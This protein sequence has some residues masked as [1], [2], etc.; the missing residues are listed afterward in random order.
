MWLL[1]YVNIAT[2]ERNKDDRPRGNP[3]HYI[4]KVQV[5]ALSRRKDEEEKNKTMD[6][7]ESVELHAKVSKC[8][9]QPFVI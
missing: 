9:K 8:V 6:T 7:S 4:L 5:K 1:A 3:L 2:S